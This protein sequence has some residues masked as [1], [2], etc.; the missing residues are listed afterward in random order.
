MLFSCFRSPSPE[1]T[2]DGQGNRTNTR[3]QRVKEKL[4]LE[5][6]QLILRAMRMYPGFKAPADYVP[7][8]LKKWKR[9][10]FP[11]EKHS[12][13][14]FLGLVV[15]P[16]G[17][18][19]RKMEKETG[20]KISI[21]GKGAHKDGK[22][23]KDGKHDPDED[24]PLHVHISADT[25]DA[26]E[27]GVKAINELLAPL[28]TPLKYEWKKAQL[29]ELAI[30]NGTLRPER[31]T[32]I[33][34]QSFQRADV[35][36]MICGDASHPTH[37]CPIKNGRPISTANNTAGGAAVAYPWARSGNSEV[38]DEYKQFLDA[39]GENNRREKSRDD[40]RLWGTIYSGVLLL[41]LCK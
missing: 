12:D 27:R 36:C 31:P 9:I 20:C 38:D 16:R 10:Y 34:E 4:L 39:I 26:V 24:L 5:R 30:I 1:P 2:Y 13:I 40:G 23:R 19:Q 14:N 15:G 8:S 28:D 32:P 29:R 35:K 3:Q 18:N 17:M 22:M 7:I 11:I 37:D 21:R 41:L 25:M 33:P 6:Q